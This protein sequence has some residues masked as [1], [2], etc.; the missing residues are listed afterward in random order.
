MGHKLILTG[1]SHYESV[2]VFLRE[3]NLLA[4]VLCVHGLTEPEL[5]ACYKMADL[6]V[7]PSLS[8]GGMPFTFTEALSV[9]T[10]AILA[11][12]DVTR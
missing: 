1:F 8:E 10:P 2:R 12:I 5:A 11:D 7:S 9:E 4:D 6:A 3:H